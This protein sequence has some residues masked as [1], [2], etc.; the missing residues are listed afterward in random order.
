MLQLP[1]KDY[2][3]LSILNSSTNWVHS[4]ICINGVILSVEYIYNVKAEGP[5]EEVDKQVGRQNQV[6]SMRKE[7]KYKK[8][9]CENIIDQ[10]I[11]LYA[12][13]KF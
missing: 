4:N 6:S 10:V 8:S 3:S 12:N 1:Q 9:M 11:I 2:S 13:F 7:V 5:K